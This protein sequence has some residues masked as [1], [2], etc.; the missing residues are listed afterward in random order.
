MN[1]S[2]VKKSTKELDLSELSDEDSSSYDDEEGFDETTQLKS[3]KIDDVDKSTFTG[4]SASKVANK[5]SEK[6][7]LPTKQR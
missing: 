7:R 4:G 5:S 2:S 3:I 1:S 6:G